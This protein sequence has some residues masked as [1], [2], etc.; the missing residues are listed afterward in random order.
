MLTWN[1]EAGMRGFLAAL[2]FACLPAAMNHAMAQSVTG[3]RGT[4][5]NVLPITIESGSQV[6]R[7]F[8][9]GLTVCMPGSATNCQVFDRVVVD[10]G[11]SGLTILSSALGP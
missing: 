3:A 11:S 8:T 1:R 4:N 9:S 2:L 7:I 5:A 6:N 10:T